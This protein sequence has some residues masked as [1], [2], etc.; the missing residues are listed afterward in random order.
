MKDNEEDFVVDTK[1]QRTDSMGSV[2]APH[3]Y[4]FHSLS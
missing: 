3:K 2:R 4:A 1:I